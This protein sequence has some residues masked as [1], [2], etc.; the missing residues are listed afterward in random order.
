VL[1]SHCDSLTGATSTG[2][3]VS[4]TASSYSEHLAESDFIDDSGSGQ[5]ASSAT[6]GSTS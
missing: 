6:L 1:P 4:Q 5:S 3:A 2:L